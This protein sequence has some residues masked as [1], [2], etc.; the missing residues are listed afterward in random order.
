[1]VDLP[2]LHFRTHPRH[3]TQRPLQALGRGVIR[4]P[5]GTVWAVLLSISLIVRDGVSGKLG[6]E[7]RAWVGS[8]RNE[9]RILV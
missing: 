4:V 5:S 3:T 6:N 1:M 2:L 7:M 9:K 8:V